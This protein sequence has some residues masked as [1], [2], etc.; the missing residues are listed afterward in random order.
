MY[1]MQLAIFYY[2]IFRH[3]HHV[4]YIDD[5]VLHVL[6]VL[7]QINTHTNKSLECG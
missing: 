5:Y 3:V 2:P 6:H 4:F 7:R 1:D